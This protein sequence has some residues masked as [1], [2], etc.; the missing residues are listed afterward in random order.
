MVEEEL[1]GVEK[2]PDDVLVGCLLL[3]L[4]KVSKGEV[5]LLTLRFPGVEPEVQLPELVLVRPLLI[6]LRT[7]ALPLPA[8]IFPRT[9]LEF[10]RWRL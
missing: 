1:L 7:P 3:T 10:S 6:L 4:A 8:E 9:S 2:G 5:D